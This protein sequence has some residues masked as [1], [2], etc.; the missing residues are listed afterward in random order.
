MKKQ[1]YLNKFLSVLSLFALVSTFTYAGADVLVGTYGAGGGDGLSN[2]T[3]AFISSAADLQTLAANQDD[4]NNHFILTTDIDLEGDSIT[5]GTAAAPFTA[6]FDGYNHTI[7][8]L[9]I[10]S[11]N[12][13]V[14]LFGVAQAAQI[15]NLGMINPHIDGLWNATNVG[16][17][18]G[19]LTWEAGAIINCFVQGGYVKHGGGRYGA[20]VG[21]IIQGSITN[22]YSSCEVVGGWNV[23]GAVGQL[24]DSWT[25]GEIAS[26][27]VV[28]GSSNLK[29]VIGTPAGAG[30][31]TMNNYYISTAGTDDVAIATSLTE[32]QLRAEANYVGFTFDASN[33]TMSS[34]GFA[35]LSSFGTKAS[36]IIITSSVANGHGTISPLGEQSV[37]FGENTVFTI[38]PDA[39]YSATKLVIN[40]ET[41]DYDPGATS[42]TFTAPVYNSSV[43]AIFEYNGATKLEE[44]VSGLRAY[45][46][47]GQIVIQNDAAFA[48]K[49]F[50]MNG[51]LL[52]SGDT[53]EDSIKLSLSKAGIY[54]LHVQDNKMTTT[55][56]VVVY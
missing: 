10:T 47:V 50:D 9:A 28:Y 6:S 11:T 54:V 45:G 41:V 31:T 46:V 48:Y 33:W 37:G 7:S 25:T 12:A 14:G 18:V 20:I 5:I 29:A 4:W 15:M 30:M 1:S 42:Y 26:G 52:L 36:E 38:T 22:C 24:G 35:V 53:S 34:N 44:V 3:P 39:N 49:V 2:L 27:V 16:A 51:K 40:G 8:N 13:N 19:Q 17:I 43:E 56:K 32:S 23:G 21:W 55:K